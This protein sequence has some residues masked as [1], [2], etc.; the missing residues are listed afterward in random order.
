M[1]SLHMLGGRNDLAF[2]TRYVRQMAHYSDDGGKTQ[3]GAYG[4]RWRR[5]FKRDQLD[6]AVQRLQLDKNDRRVVIQM[7]DA[8]TDQPAADAGGRDIPCNLMMHPQIL[9]DGSLGLTVFCRANDMVWG[10]YGA[11]A[12]HFSMVHE[13]LA[14]SLGVSI[15][16]YW[17]VSDNYHAYV[18][19]LKPI[20]H[21]G[22]DMIPDEPY[23]KGEVA[24][25]PIMS[26]DRKTWNQDLGI[27]LDQ[28]P[29]V[30][31]R[32]PFFRKVVTPIEQAHKAYRQ[33][34]GP[35]RYDVPLEI[36]EQCK[37][38]DWRRACQ[39]W[40]LRRKDAYERARD[41]GPDHSK[42]ETENAK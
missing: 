7:Y 12:V 34:K 1:E 2:L 36:L 31:F 5:H 42:T 17:Q 8:D 23:T 38:T 37:A 9:V 32:E 25:Y 10:A 21:Y 33:T 13:Y 26:V 18:T 15:G 4:H 22:L 41:A 30:G 14:A 6:W 3:P 29:I 39:E 27:F 20:E 40:I 24:P 28:G 16:P 35:Q 19:T 11:N